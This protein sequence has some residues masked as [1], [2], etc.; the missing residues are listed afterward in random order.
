MLNG[1]VYALPTV[2][3]TINAIDGGSW[4]STPS[5]SDVQ[6]ERRAEHGE[7]FVTATGTVRR[8]NENGTSS[9][10]GLAGLVRMWPT[11][12]SSDNRDRGNLSTP[13]IARRV[14]KGKQVM[15]SMSVSTDS[16]RL[17]PTWVEWLMAFPLEFTASKDWVTPKF[18]CRRQSPGNCS[19]V[20]K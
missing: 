17:N 7:H 10:L 19:E 5:A 13:A 11:P 14:A 3:R 20:S 9:N 12:C 18:P 1:Y 4:L 8:R 16:G 15:L 6:L 2:G